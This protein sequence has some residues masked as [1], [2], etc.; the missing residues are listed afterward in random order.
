MDNEV[1]VKMVKLTGSDNDAEVVM[2]LRGLQGMLS[3][4]GIDFPGVFK[5]VLAHLADIKAQYPKATAQAPK[6]P[7][8]VTLSGMPQCRVPK[9]GCVEL[10]PPGKLEGIVVQMQGAAADAADVISLGMKDALVAAILNKSRFKLKIFDVK[11]N[12]GDV[13]ESILQ[14]E[15]E[16]EGMMPVKVWSNVRGEVA[17]LA[18]VMRQGVKTGFP[19]LAA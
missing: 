4:E 19:E 17:A 16:R 15:Y 13:M 7:A 10:I 3:D 18:T 9:P 5:Y 12:R 14:A 2:G 1:F 8:P 6:G 11:N